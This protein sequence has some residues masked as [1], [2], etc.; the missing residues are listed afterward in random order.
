MRIL[1]ISGREPSYARNK[2]IL[3][4][5]KKN[6]AEIIE[7]SS[8]RHPLIRYPLVLAKFLAKRG[9][10]HDIVFLGFYSQPLLPI[11][12]RLTSKPLILD[13]FLSGYQ[14]I[15]FDKKKFKKSSLI[16]K[17]F[18]HWDENSIQADKILLDTNQHCDY[19]SKEFN[20]PSLK[21]QRIWIG[22]DDDVFYPMPAKEKKFIVEFH[23]GFIPLQ[24]TEYIVKAAKLLE[25]HDVIFIMVGDG[26]TYKKCRQLAKKLKLKNL[27]FFGSKPNIE[28]PKYIASASVGLGIFG[29]TQK[30]SLVVPNKA[31]EVIA[32]KK[33]L[34]TAKTKA[35][36]ELFTH[37]KN[38]Y[39]FSP[40]SPKSLA[41]AILTIKNNK[42]LREKIAKGGY[43]LFK[44]NATPGV[45]GK[46][47]LSICRSLKHNL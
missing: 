17:L 6:G 38:V 20:I 26:Q 22:A 39:F 23:G 37:K 3:K 7:C 14:T 42:Q 10:P 31:Y 33:P 19:F 16:A 21:L 43:D 25:K 35:A 13:A 36:E 40:A 29:D 5:L 8:S 30:T 1:F 32:M 12:R 47:I 9:T 46:Q 18:R 11:I 4:G 28:I 34:I 27:R 15:A 2:I 44:K 24:G 45:I 41:D